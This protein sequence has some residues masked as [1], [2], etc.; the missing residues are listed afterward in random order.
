[1]HKNQHQETRQPFGPAPPDP[2]AFDLWMQLVRRCVIDPL[3]H[4]ARALQ[5]S[6]RKLL[7]NWRNVSKGQAR[8]RKKPSH[9]Q[10]KRP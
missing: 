8:N 2:D 4:S 1:M 3:L 6:A 5:R 10:L 7:L 9:S